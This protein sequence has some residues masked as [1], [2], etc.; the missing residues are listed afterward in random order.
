MY[1]PL[2]DG[3]E[4]RRNFTSGEVSNY[5]VVMCMFLHTKWSMSIFLYRWVEFAA[6]YSV[7]KV[8]VSSCCVDFAVDLEGGGE[9]PD[10]CCLATFI[11]V[12]WSGDLVYHTRSPPQPT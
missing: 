8:V 9:W 3:M 5:L 1:F 6:L 7:E 11:T 12:N 10:V 4:T 2:F